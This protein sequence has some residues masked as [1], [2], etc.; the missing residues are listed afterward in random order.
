MHRPVYVRWAARY[1]SC[2][3]DA[4]EAV[5]DAFLALLRIWPKVLSFENPA[6]Y[7]WSVLKNRVIDHARARGRRPSLMD[8]ATFDTVALR[9]ATDP[10]GELEEHLHLFRAIGEL[11]PRQQDVVVLLHCEGYST[12]EVASHLGITD[13][14]VR[15]IDRYAKRRLREVLGTPERATDAPERATDTPRESSAPRSEGAAEA[16]ERVEEEGKKSR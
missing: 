4:E 16:A 13:A 12:A 5:D 7:A 3:A 14:G 9:T 1:L 15:S 2:R 6:A 11:P 10:I 8:A